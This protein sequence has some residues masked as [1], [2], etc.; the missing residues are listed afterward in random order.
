MKLIRNNPKLK[1]RRRE[2][3]RNQTDAEK[4]L[5]HHLRNRQLNGMKFLRQYSVGPYILDF[6][7]SGLKFAIELDG[8]QHAEED[9]REYDDFRSEYLKTHGIETV[10]FWNNEVMV[11]TEGVLERIAERLK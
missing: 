1:Q 5:W 6:Y 7:C 9:K 3:R 10:R 8:G 2:L 11:N 4:V